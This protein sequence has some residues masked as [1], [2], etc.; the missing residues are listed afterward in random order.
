MGHRQ[1][2]DAYL[3]EIAKQNGA[4]LLTFDTKLRALGSEVVELLSPRL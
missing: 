1:V 2:T 4:V 3:I